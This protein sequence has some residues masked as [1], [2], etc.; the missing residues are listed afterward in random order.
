MGI[1]YVVAVGH[2]LVRCSFQGPPNTVRGPL[3]MTG[4]E[5]VPCATFQTSSCKLC[6]EKKEILFLF[7]LCRP[8]WSESAEQT[9]VDMWLA[10]NPAPDS[11][12]PI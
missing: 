6:A 9:P 10:D 11:C 5:K 8:T 1:W 12:V 4:F 3:A 2:Q 7:V